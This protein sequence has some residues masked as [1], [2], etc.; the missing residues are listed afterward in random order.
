MPATKTT[1]ITGNSTTL[2]ASSAMT[3]AREG[4]TGSVSIIQA[5]TG[6]WSL[7]SSPDLG[8]TLFDL[9]DAAGNPQTGT[10]S[11]QVNFNLGQGAYGQDM[12]VYIVYT[13]ASGLSSKVMAH[14][15]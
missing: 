9:K 7:K 2:I 6:T 5:G 1:N 3:R 14:M 8:T 13:G 4:F 15:N 10:A 12:Q 11:G